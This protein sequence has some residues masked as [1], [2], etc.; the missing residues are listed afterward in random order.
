MNIDLKA[1]TQ[2]LLNTNHGQD[3]G[4][5]SNQPASS[6]GLPAF[7]QLLSSQVRVFQE[8]D[9]KN[10][11]NTAQLLSPKIEQAS[12][13]EAKEEAR[14]L[15]HAGQAT[16]ISDWID[17]GKLAYGASTQTLANSQNH[18]LNSRTELAYAKLAEMQS[19]ANNMRSLSKGASLTS[20]GVDDRVEFSILNARQLNASIAFGK[21]GALGDANKDTISPKSIPNNDSEAIT[22]LGVSM[23]EQPGNR[24]HSQGGDAQSNADES[25]Q[26]RTNSLQ[27][28][29]HASF[30]S[31]QWSE[32]I[33]QKLV[34]MI[35]ANM[36]CAVLNLNPENLGPLK[37]L[38]SVQDQMVNSTF[39]SNSSDVRQGLQD[40]MENLRASMEKSGL[41]LGQVDIRSAKSFQESQDQILVSLKSE[42]ADELAQLI[43]DYDNQNR[44]LSPDGT[45]NV[46]V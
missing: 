20:S 37:I 43:S 39:V 36:H 2:S 16:R 21:A 9:A 34:F 30:G 29:I 28:Q 11:V 24:Q 6:S 8:Q 22:T 42:Q 38:I 27:G 23:S 17:P 40:G 4:T 41:V 5:S 3:L 45:V 26:T 31:L 14:Q 18:A 32:E 1:Q 10:T 12:K 19:Q 44:G 35:S 13:I 7:G 25:I 46:F 15:N 33:S